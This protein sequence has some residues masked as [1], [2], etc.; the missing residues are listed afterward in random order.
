MVK[1]FHI[2]SLWYT[3]LLASLF[4][5]SGFAQNT[6]N[7]KTDKTKYNALWK[8]VD[9]LD[10]KRLPK[11]AYKVMNE[12]YGLAKKDNNTGQL[13]KCTIYKLRYIGQVEENSLVEALNN[14]RKEA[15]EAK[16]PSKPLLHSMLAQIYW[17]F[18]QVNRYR[19]LKRSATANFKEEDIDTW[20]LNKIVQETVRNYQLSLADPTKLQATKIGIYDEVLKKGNVKQRAFRPTLYDFLAHRAIDFFQSSEPSITRPAYQFTLNKN[21]YLQDV[22]KFAKLKITTKDTLSYKFYMITILQDLVKFHLKDNNLAALA[23]VDLKRLSF[24]YRHLTANNKDQ[25]YLNALRKLEQKSLQFPVSSRVTYAIAQVIYNQ[26][27]KYRPLQSDQYKW[28][29][30]EALKITQTGI[31]RFPNSD[32]AIQCSNLQK[33]IRNKYLQVTIE[34]TNLSG[35]PFRALVKYRNINKVHWRFFKTSMKEL[36]KAR[37][38]YSTSEL[39]GYFLKKKSVTATVSTLPD[40]GDFQNHSVEE[41]LPKLEYGVYVAIASYREDFQ[42]SQNGLAYTY[43]TISDIAWMHRRNVDNGTTEFYTVNRQ[44]GAPL[45]GVKAQVWLSKYNYRLSRYVKING[46]VFYSNA[47]GYIKVPYSQK[48]QERNFYVEFTKGNDR[49]YTL[50]PRNFYN[51]YGNLYRYKASKPK[52]RTKVFFFLDRKIY[53]PGQTIYFKGIVLSTDGETHQL[54]T[55][56]KSEVT[57]YDVNR[58]KQATLKVTTNEYGTFSGTFIAPNN[59]LNGQ[60]RISSNAGKYYANSVTFSVEDYKR[61][62]FEVKFN[63]I[64]GS[65]RLNETIVA[66]A[67][68]KAYSGANIDGAQVKYRVVRRARFPYWFY[69]YYGYYPTSPQMEIT[70]GVAKTDENGEVEIK[71]KAIPDLSVDRKSDPIFTY[72]IYADVTDLNGE[73]RSGSRSVGVGYRA[74]EMSVGVGNQVNQLEEAVWKLN[75]TNLS[76]T[77]EPAQGTITIHRLKTP[78]RTYRARRWGRPDRFL[79]TAQEWQKL[80]PA[81]LYADENNRYL[82]AK[83]QEV[84]SGAFDTKKDKKLAIEAIKNWETGYYILEMKAKDKFGEVVKTVKYFEVFNPKGQSLATNEINYFNVLKGSAEPGEKAQLLVGTTLPKVNILY[85]LE[86]KN[87]IIKTEWLTLKKQQRLLEI[88]ITEAYRGNLSVNYVFVYNNRFYNRAQAIEVPWT[89]KALDIRFETFRNKLNPGAKEEWRLKIKGKQ[90]DRVAA[91]MVATLYDASLD[92]FRSNSF[93]FGVYQNYYAQLRW[94][95]DNGFN[96][97]IF[98]NYTRYWN[99][100]KRTLYQRND[101]LNW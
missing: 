61:P 97:S 54:L 37:R 41:K 24:A 11:D 58:Q 30:K 44:S 79:Y 2:P 18:Y 50:S 42:L 36:K 87:K 73:T 32:G 45:S 31:D 60:M 16:F 34:E 15:N 74:L 3:V 95:S 55:N 78:Q 48:N 91:E 4:S 75:T 77:F 92:V 35:E 7:E 62:K 29:K 39:L 93:N 17:Q 49:I 90:G 70:N 23:D 43:F 21:D 96:T 94:R 72:T 99:P 19:F 25:L 46:G 89:N 13:V 51:A 56:N 57:L 5:V 59:G 83:G 100:R 88:P 80:F 101:E 9:S 64:K 53:R 14:L 22:E 82:W 81:D 67:K 8:K 68:A 69:Y 27:K 63:P 6:S 85:E 38:K 71:F 98:R 47:Q 66:K 84:Y 65:F 86:H 52:I 26:G 33:T 28:K 76:G 40:D 20:D 10:R 1:N 12:I